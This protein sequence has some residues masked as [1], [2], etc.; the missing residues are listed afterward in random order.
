MFIL[1][2]IIHKEFLFA[3]AKMLP[4]LVVK[5]R[6]KVQVTGLKKTTNLA[7][8]GSTWLSESY[9]ICRVAN[10]LCVQ[11]PS[12][13]SNENGVR[14]TVPTILSISILNV[15]LIILKSW[16]QNMC[17]NLRKGRHTSF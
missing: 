10:T 9:D 11:T 2:K 14:F 17:C 7:V 6:V 15:E 4:I 8:K 3:K 1:K 16:G 13:P 5:N 12:T